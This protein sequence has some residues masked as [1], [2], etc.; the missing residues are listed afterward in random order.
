MAPLFA[1]MLLVILALMGLALDGSRLFN[2]R[3]E[4]Q[5]VADFAAMSAAQKLVGTAAG[6]DDALAAAAAA[7]AVQKYKYGKSSIAWS[8]AAV[9]FSDSPTSG[10]MG[11]SAAR[12]TPENMLFVRVDTAELSADNGTIDLVFAKLQAK[13]RTGATSASAVAGRSTVNLTPLAVC[14]MSPMP[15]ASRP[16]NAELV[17]YGFRRGVAYDLMQLNPAGTTPA[18]FIINP[19]DLGTGVGKVSNTTPAVVAPFVCTGTMPAVGGVG[20]RL[21]VSQPFP[22]AALFE[23]LNSRFG[24]YPDAAACDFRAA[25]PDANI[26]PFSF[27]SNPSWMKTA[28]S[29]QTAKQRIETKRLHTVADLTPKAAGEPLDPDPPTAA[30]YGQ[31]WSYA[32]PVPHSAYTAGV[33]E[34]TTGYTPFPSTMWPSLYAPGAPEP[35]GSYPALT[36]YMTGNTYHTA[37]PA[38]YGRPVR[39]RRVLHVPLVDCPVAGSNATVRAIGRFFM[40]VPA[41][42]TSINAEFAGIASG[43]SL[44][45]A[46]ELFK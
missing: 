39:H 6:I 3:V 7:A 22:I 13:D 18:N 34:P 31:M 41:T 29:G 1:V 46:V 21:H 44:Q 33:P 2:R 5:A 28:P 12:S 27:D 23:H 25:P 9:E 8:D 19:I 26:K 17:E 38:I 45:G 10:W 30:M 32:R 35:K 40:T 43:Q 15:A 42:S 14:A 36:P 4:L 24:Q 37:P 16:P 11:A 20:G